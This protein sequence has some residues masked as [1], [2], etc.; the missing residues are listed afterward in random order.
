MLRSELIEILQ[1]TTRDCRRDGEVMIEFVYKV[2][3]DS[4]GVIQLEPSDRELMPVLSATEMLGWGN[5]ITLLVVVGD[6]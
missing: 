6:D 1:Q 5:A 4:Q 2:G 3:V